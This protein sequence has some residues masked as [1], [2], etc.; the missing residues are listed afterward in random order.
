M[1]AMGRKRE[2]REKGKKTRGDT[3]CNLDGQYT[4]PIRSFRDLTP[5]SIQ[6]AISRSRYLQLLISLTLIGAILRF[7]NLGYNSIWLDEASTLN[8][9]IK[10]IP[11]IWQATTA[12]EFNPPLFYWTEHIML[13][14]GNSEVV[15]RFIPALLGV[16]TIP[17]IYLVGK[18]FMDRNTGIIAAT[19]F[20]F[21]PFLI[22]YSQD[23]RAYSM[24][25]FFVTFAMVFYFRA[26]KSND[27]TNWAL[28]GV[29]SALAFWTHFYALVII[30]ALILYALYELL[31]KIKNSINAVKPLAI[32]CAIFGVI[33]LPLIIVTIQLFAKRTASAPTFGI[34]GPD[35]IFATFAQISCWNTQLPGSAIALDLLLLL[36]IAGIVQAFMLDKN[37]GIFLVTITVLTFVI[38]NFLSYR[39]PMQPRYL[40]FLAIVYF[41]AIALSYRLLYTL[42]NSRGV[43]YGFIIILVLMNAFLLVGYYSGYVKED[44]RGFAGGLQQ[45]TEQGDFVVIVPGYVSQPLDYYYS[46]RSD[47]TMEFSAYTANDLKAINAQKNNNTIFFVV[48]GDISAANPEGDAA[49]W[50]GQNTKSLGQNTGIF[51]LSSA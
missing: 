23:A 6:E 12:G 28:F 21:S 34:Q 7:Y 33:C 9:A 37:K 8:F 27:L 5:G 18:E 41:I 14:F 20:A 32:A 44:W 48:T 4:N 24:M 17:L 46:N 10:S 31:P 13:I 51:L 39:I 50:L 30:G 43:V 36:F 19:A 42:V 47:Q 11:D 38:S 35:I 40:I 15:L 2:D 1:T 26:L 3:E 49:E 45:I 25:L 22:F 29:L 16:L